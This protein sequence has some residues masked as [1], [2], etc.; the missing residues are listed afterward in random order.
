[1]QAKA[2]LTEH[3]PRYLSAKAAHRDRKALMEGILRNTLA[4]P[5]RGVEKEQHQVR[6]TS[7]WFFTPTVNFMA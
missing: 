7:L 5:P 1:M 2:L 3:T 4:R 6:S